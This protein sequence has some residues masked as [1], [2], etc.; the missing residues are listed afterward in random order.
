VDERLGPVRVR[1]LQVHQVGQGFR[2]GQ[3]PHIGL[4]E[5]DQTWIPQQAWRNVG[6]RLGGRPAHAAR[7]DE[8]GRRR[9]GRHGGGDRNADHL[10]RPAVQSDRITH[11][12]IERVGEGGLDHYAAVADP[13]ALSQLGLV[14]RRGPGVAPHGLHI[15]RST[16][17]PKLRRGDRVRAAVADDAG[18][19]GQFLEA[20]KLRGPLDAGDHVWSV[21][22]LPGALVRVAA[23]SRRTSPS[24]NVVVAAMTASSSSA[25]SRRRRR[26][27]RTARRPTSRQCPT[28]GTGPI[29]LSPRA[30]QGRRAARWCRRTTWSRPRTHR[31]AS[32]SAGPRWP[33]S[34]RRG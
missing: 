19:A 32:R 22:R 24:V 12:Q 25:A 14:D 3:A 6:Q 23:A 1:Q 30:R 27:S 13:A 20:G 7:R 2:G 18:I 10:E 4:G 11:A 28:I 29:A 34:A 17:G 16:G 9:I 31:R 8:A 21:G 26:R 33:R 5:P 15:R